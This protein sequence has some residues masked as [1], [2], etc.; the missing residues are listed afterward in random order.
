MVALIAGVV[1]VSVVLIAAALT[2]RDMGGRGC[3]APADPALDLRMRSA[4]AEVSPPPIS[5]RRD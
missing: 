5:P 3:C 1:F 4:R 2:S